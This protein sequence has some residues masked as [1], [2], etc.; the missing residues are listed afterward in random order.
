MVEA[1]NRRAPV[2]IASMWR[3]GLLGRA[4]RPAAGLRGMLA[5]QQ[6]ERSHLVA[7]VQQRLAANRLC[8]AVDGEFGPRTR[9]ALVAFQRARGL[10]SD[11]VVGAH[12]WGALVSSGRMRSQARC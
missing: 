3:P 9:R 4:T 10:A 8:V 12:T 2:R 6:G 11:G 1:P 7:A 5:V